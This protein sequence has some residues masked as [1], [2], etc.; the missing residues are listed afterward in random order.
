MES[1]T[2]SFLKNI[3]KQ[4]HFLKNL[5]G[6]KILYV[7]LYGPWTHPAQYSDLILR[8]PVKVST[9]IPAVQ[10]CPLKPPAG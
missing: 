9:H 8:F 6:I 3:Y 7:H 5:F 4:T 1:N 10:F 2:K